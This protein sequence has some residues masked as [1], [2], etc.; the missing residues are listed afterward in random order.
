MLKVKT[1]MRFRCLPLIVAFLAFAPG[2]ARADSIAEKAEVCGSCHGEKGVPQ[3]KIT[4]VIW[5]QSVGYL[6]LQLRDF[7]KGARVHEIMQAVVAD[8]EKDELLALAE[9]FSAKPWPALGQP[10]APDAVTRKALAANTSVGCTGCHL[11]KYQGDGGSVPR[12][13]G[14]SREYMAKTTAEFRTRA[15]GNNPGMSDLMKA[16][17]EDDLAALSEFLA[18]L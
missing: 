2:A 9:Y 17:A 16:T 15:R 18:G 3:E 11:D 4:P 6:Y 1:Q 13:A 7:K 12:L 10:T 5:G 8:L 14:Q